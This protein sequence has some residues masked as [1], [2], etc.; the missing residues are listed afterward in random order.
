MT[1][2]VADT[3]KLRSLRKASFTLTPIWFV[4][5]ISMFIMS[6]FSNFKTDF[7][8][9]MSFQKCV[10][11]QQSNNNE[12]LLTAGADGHLRVFQTRTSHKG[13]D[14]PAHNNDVDSLDISP[15]SVHQSV[16]G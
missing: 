3:G 12:V 11:V 13:A 10:V 9:K 16:I 5:L 14:S 2:P 15:V 8:P 1:Q 4:G 6:I 7:A